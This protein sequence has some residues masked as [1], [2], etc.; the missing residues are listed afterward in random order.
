MLQDEVCTLAKRHLVC[1]RDTDNGSIL[2][3]LFH[4]ATDDC[5]KALNQIFIAF[6]QNTPA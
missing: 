6:T 4:L 5:K 1:V 2:K 3:H